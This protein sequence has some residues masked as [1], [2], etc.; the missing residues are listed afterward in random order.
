MK[1][2][3]R[4]YLDRV[5]DILVRDTRIDYEKEKVYPPFYSNPFLSLSFFSYL[6]SLF[7]KHPTPSHSSNHFLQ[8]FSRYCKD[9]YGIVGDELEY[10]WNQY[11]DIIKDKIRNNER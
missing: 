10:V 8:F 5:V 11:R 4:K 3:Q 2:N 7:Y 6:S 1:S 9:T